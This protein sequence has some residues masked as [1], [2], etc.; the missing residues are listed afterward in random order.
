M[1]CLRMWCL[2]IADAA[3]SIVQFIIRHGEQTIII[4]H[5]LKHHILELRSI[6]VYM[7]ICILCI[8]IYIYIH[9]KHNKTN[10]YIYIYTYH[11]YIYL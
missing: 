9:I 11:L 5:I 2:M 6:Y 1:W 8:Y 4:K 3:N 7:Y 10:I